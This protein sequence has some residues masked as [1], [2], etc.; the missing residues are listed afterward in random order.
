MD[1]NIKEKVYAFIDSQ[2]LNLGVQEQGWNLDFRRF[3]VYLKDK[4]NVEKCFLFIGYVEEQA[5][6]YKNLIDFGY[7]MIFKPTLEFKNKSG[8]VVKGNVDSEL[9]LHAMKELPNYDKAVI[10]SGDG[11]FHCLIEYLISIN[12]LGR[13]VIPN[14]KQYSALL[15][16]YRSYMLFLSNNLRKKLEYHKQEEQENHPSSPKIE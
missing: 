2:N 1:N 7:I 14:S 4:C 6:L 3:R 13:L 5:Q 16:E 11:D 9:V 10:V 15:R 12:K 8:T